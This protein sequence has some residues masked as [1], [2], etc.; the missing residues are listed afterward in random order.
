MLGPLSVILIAAALLGFAFWIW[1]RRTPD[2][3]A[4]EP[5]SQ[6]RKTAY[7]SR[8]D[9]LPAAAPRVPPP[10]VAQTVAPTQMLE[11]PDFESSPATE[12]L[13]VSEMLGAPDLDDSAP[14]TAFCRDTIVA[15][16]KTAR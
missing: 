5:A 10:T 12:Y 14:T 7:L 4:I 11:R 13:S 6:A 15:S 1:P 8:G 2:T 16:S 3:P 9:M